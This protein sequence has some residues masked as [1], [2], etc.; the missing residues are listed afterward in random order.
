MGR[1]RHGALRTDCD[2]LG[3]R[4]GLS[5]SPGQGSWT[6]YQHGSTCRS[7]AAEL[8]EI[9]RM[10]TALYKRIQ[11]MFQRGKRLVVCAANS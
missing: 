8:D 1:R 11:T 5:H 3:E 7:M 10:L 2:G 9:R 4:G 6:I